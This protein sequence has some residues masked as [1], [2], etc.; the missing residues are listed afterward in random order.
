MRHM[1]QPDDSREARLNGSDRM[2]L[3]A[4]LIG[5][6]LLLTTAAA[7]AYQLRPG[8]VEAPADTV[9]KPGSGYDVSLPES[10]PYFAESWVNPLQHTPSSHC[11]VIS[12]LPSGDL[13][14]VWY[15]GSR[16][17]ASD[18]A[19]YTSRLPKGCGV[20]SPPVVAVDRVM[21]QREL[22]RYIKKVGNAVIFP[23]RK[24]RMWMVYVTVSMGG[25][26]GCT[27]NLKVS[28]DD[29]RT[30]GESQRLTLNPF[31]NLST[32]VRNKPIYASDGR[33]GLPVYHEMARKFPQVLWLNPQDDG[34]LEYRVRSLPWKPGLIQPALVAMEDD[35]VL[36]ILRDAGD[37]RCLRTSISSDNGW[38]WSGTSMSGLP[39]PDSAV[40][41]LR[42]RDGR[43]LLAYNDC[44]LGRENLRLALSSDGGRNW[45]PGAYLEREG[46][47]EFSYPYLLQDAFG[48]I[49]VSDTWKRKRIRHVQF[50]LAWLEAGGPSRSPSS[51]Q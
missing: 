18:V 46:S 4:R 50:N 29:G 13:M 44:E 22:D 17:G 28:A 15:G 36:M 19:I 40:D 31:L 38:T 48:R 27:L 16:E 20:W 23:D 26:S 3:R 25:W 34:R 6:G 21:A 1:M 51:A 24:G 47:G 7:V 41:A 14:A 33:I 39:N 32:L 2:C 42:L 12:S 30:W 11:S 10:S 37:G 43:I 8:D 45:T 9:S 5:M 49:H 35:R